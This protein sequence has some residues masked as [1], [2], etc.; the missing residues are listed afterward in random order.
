MW[1]N[2]WW[3]SV[4]FLS[5]I[6][7]PCCPNSTPTRFWFRY[8]KQSLIM[9][10]Y[11]FLNWMSFSLI[12]LS[13]SVFFCSRQATDTSHRRQRGERWW[14]SFTPSWASRWCCSACRTSATR[15]PSRSSS[16]TGR[17]AA[18]C[19]RSGPR[20]SV[21]EAGAKASGS[22]TG[23]RKRG[24]RWKHVPV[25]SAFQ[26]KKIICRSRLLLAFFLNVGQISL[27]SFDSWM[28]AT[29]LII[30]YICDDEKKNSWIWATSWYHCVTEDS[31]ISKMSVINPLQARVHLQ[32]RKN[33]HAWI[34]N[35][36][37]Q[38]IRIFLFC[39]IDLHIRN[40][41]LQS[42]KQLWVSQLQKSEF[43]VL[44]LGFEKL[45]LELDDCWRT[46]KN[47]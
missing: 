17:C 14:R 36:Q 7:I 15:W 6:L 2:R 20:S 24:R 22:G 28:S 38:L 47:V 3:F 21:L 18:T 19:A 46:T 26:K 11:C 40:C 27:E 1:T 16:S 33:Y 25:N 13:L 42:Y 9:H 32:T 31:R 37:P 5:I 44:V 43:A 35:P 8:I 39:L 29:L 34:A 23:R 10:S 12:T 4:K 45:G 41:E 30:Y